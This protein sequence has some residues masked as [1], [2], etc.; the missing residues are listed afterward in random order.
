MR[1]PNRTQH[2]SAMPMVPMM[3]TERQKTPPKSLWTLPEA[4][5]LR[6]SRKSPYTSRSI[7]PFMNVEMA[8]MGLMTT[9]AKSPRGSG[10]DGA[11][12]GGPK[13]PLLDEAVLDNRRES[14]EAPDIDGVPN[15]DAREPTH[16][17]QIPVLLR[18]P[19]G[20]PSHRVPPNLC[21]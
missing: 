14:K 12:G 8:S 18:Q 15:D 9:P 7:S 21:C 10:G 20:G 5:F 17:R 19:H 1:G 4:L 3:F 13:F 11:R 2:S 16:Y 6:V